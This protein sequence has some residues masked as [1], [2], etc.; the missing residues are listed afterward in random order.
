[1]VRSAMFAFFDVSWKCLSI[2]ITNAHVTPPTQ[3]FRAHT[4]SAFDTSVKRSG[5]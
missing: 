2:D 4:T 5:H 3:R 1:M